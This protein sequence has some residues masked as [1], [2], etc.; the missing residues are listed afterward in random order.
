MTR[1]G[2]IYWLV[3]A[4]VAIGLFTA[5]DL[6][7]IAAVAVVV[8][9]VWAW[10]RATPSARVRAEQS[11]TRGLSAG[12]SPDGRAKQPPDA[13][14]AERKITRLSSQGRIGV[15]GEHYRQAALKR[16]IGRRS[17][18]PVGSWEAGLRTMAYLVREPT[19]KHDRNAVMVQVAHDG[20]TEHI[21]YLSAEI[22]PQWQPLLRQLESQ[23]R[24]AECPCYLYR[25]GNGEYQAV[26]RAADPHEA[27]LAN[28]EPD[29]AHLLE[30]ERPCALA[31]ESDHQDV[32]RGYDPGLYWATLHPATVTS[33]KYVGR[34]TIEAR[35]DGQRVGEVSAAQGERYADLLA[36]GA[37]VACEAR[38]YDG[39]RHREVQLI[40]P[41]VD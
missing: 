10:R 34:P 12:T 35:L 2:T 17:V 25:G 3:V 5:G 26:L 1:R 28:V 7:P 31:R 22:A 6:G 30:A 16:V 19:N 33:G 36:R 24:V 9:A 18:A 23:G 11:Q 14:V 40:L 8:A 20:A 29:D 39:A 21:G 15:V 37:V 4:L 32:L 27:T 38:V 41:R 13:D